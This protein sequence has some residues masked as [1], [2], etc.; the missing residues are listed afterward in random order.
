[1]KRKD[2]A[3]TEA[4]KR[5]GQWFGSG[6]RWRRRA[7]G[8]ERELSSF[9]SRLTL[10]GSHFVGAAA[11]LLDLCGARFGV[12]V[13]PSP[14]AKNVSDGASRA[15]VIGVS[16]DDEAVKRPGSTREV[17]AFGPPSEGLQARDVVV[18]DAG[19]AA[20][21]LMKVRGRALDRLHLIAMKGD[22][23]H[24]E[25]DVDPIAVDL[26]G[27]FETLAVAKDDGVGKSRRDE[28]KPAEQ[29][30]GESETVHGIRVAAPAGDTRHRR[31]GI[32]SSRPGEHRVGQTN[33]Q[34]ARRRASRR[35]RRTATQRWPFALSSAVPGKCRSAGARAE[36]PARSR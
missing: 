21:Q 33:T 25:G 22:H 30:D 5:I 15:R 11:V 6:G 2:R 3:P 9:A 13:H 16:G 34:S 8:R 32:R 26:D 19:E 1:M 29:D 31:G 14:V 35:R 7:G 4:P 36:M 17:L 28:D 20:L 12:W 23:A 10:C 18:G 27:A 24:V